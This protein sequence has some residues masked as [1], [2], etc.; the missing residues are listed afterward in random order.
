MQRKAVC[1]HPVNREASWQGP[2]VQ[3]SQ[4]GGPLPGTR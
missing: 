4:E 3:G 1:G 2:Q